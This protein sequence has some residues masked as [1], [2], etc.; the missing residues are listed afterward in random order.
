MVI[1]TPAHHKFHISRTTHD[2]C[3]IPCFEAIIDEFLDNQDMLDE[4]EQSLEHKEWSDAYVQHPVVRS[5]CDPVLPVAFYVDGAPFNKYDG[6]ADFFV[7]NLLN[8]MKCLI[9][10]QNIALG[11]TKLVSQCIIPMRDSR[12]KSMA[13]RYQDGEAWNLEKLTCP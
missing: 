11:H 5:A 13:A 10:Q 2:A 8:A 9:Q 3:A 6:F 4:L 12:T 7:Y 1:E